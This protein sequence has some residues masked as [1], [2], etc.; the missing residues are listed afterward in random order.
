M[1]MFTEKGLVRMRT[2]LLMAVL[3]VFALT[4]L[5]G[6]SAVASASTLTIYTEDGYG[7]TM[8]VKEGMELSF[9]GSQFFTQG[10]DGTRHCEESGFTVAL[11]ENELSSVPLQGVSGYTNNCY[12]GKALLPVSYTFEPT[13]QVTFDADGGGDLPVRSVESRPSVGVDCEYTGVLDISW[14]EDGSMSYSGNLNGKSTGKGTCS[15]SSR[16]FYG[17]GSLESEEGTPVELIVTP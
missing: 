6:A 15:M 4:G 1:A 8:P 12:A 17:M 2:K 10:G 11:I 16:S 9:I 13:G 3:A 7:E 14:V 5:G